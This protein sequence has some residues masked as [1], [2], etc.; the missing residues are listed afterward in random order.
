MKSFKEYIIESEPEFN[1]DNPGGEWLKHEQNRIISKGK[2]SYGVPTLGSVTGYFSHPVNIPIEKLIKVPGRR[3]EQ[4]NVRP[5]SLEWLKSEMGKSKS[6]PKNESGS[7]QYPFIQVDHEGKPWVNEG[8]HRIMAAHALGWK[9][10]PVR[11][12][13][14]S[15]GEEINGDWHPQNIL[16]GHKNEII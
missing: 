3:G 15:G 13:Y 14:H 11:V 5:E 8:N 1:S 9:H 10:I 7:E 6:L 12:Q 2:D 4:N 16:D